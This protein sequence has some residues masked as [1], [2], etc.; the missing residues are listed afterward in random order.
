M[1]DILWL[2]FETIT[3]VAKRLKLK[4]HDPKKTFLKIFRVPKNDG[5][6]VLCLHLYFFCT[7]L[8]NAPEYITPITVILS[9]M[10]FCV[11]RTFL[12]E[13]HLDV[14]LEVLRWLDQN[15]FYKTCRYLP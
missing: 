8:K 14:V 6:P 10:K 3:K 13:R 1:V 4:S 12:V 2:N 7:F 15:F 11:A 9:F 5:S